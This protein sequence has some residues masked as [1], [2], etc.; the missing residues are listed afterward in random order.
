MT[1]G[2]CPCCG[3]DV[4]DLNAVKKRDY[5]KILKILNEIELVPKQNER[6]P[7]QV[8]R[9]R[10]ILAKKITG[11]KGLFDAKPR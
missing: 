10:N 1:P 9:F 8:Q 2:K 11:W 5:V 3:Q 7:D 4:P 6:G